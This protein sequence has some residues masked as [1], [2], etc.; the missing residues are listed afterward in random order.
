MMSKPSYEELQKEIAR[1]QQEVYA[2][3]RAE[4]NNR[5]LFDISASVNSS[6]NLNELYPAIH[7]SLSSVIDATNIFI[8]LYDRDKNVISFPYEVDTSGVDDTP[9]TGVTGKESLTARVIETRRPLLITRDEIIREREN[10]GNQIVLGR[11]PDSWLG[12]PLIAYGNLVG[13]IAV[14]S[15]EGSSFYDDNDVEILTGVADQ[16]AIAIEYKQVEQKLHES[17]ERFRIV[18]DEI[19]ELAIK[20]YNEDRQILFWN[21]GSEQLFGYSEEEAVGRQLEDLIIPVGMR[22]QVIADHE[23][24][25]ST[26]AVVPPGE[27]TLVDKFGR[28]ISVLSYHAMHPGSRGKEFFCID[29]DLRA[30]KKAEKSL[31]TSHAQFIATMDSLDVV[32]YVADMQSHEL[33]FMN[34]QAREISN[35]SIGDICWQV[36]QTGQTG[37]CPFCTNKRLIGDDGKPAPPYIWEFQN[38]KSGT[39]Y[40]CR[41]QAITWPDG[42]LVRLEIAT[43][44]DKLKSI[45][46]QLRDSEERFRVLHDASFGGICIHDQGRIVECN[47]ELSNLTGYS[48]DELCGANLL[49]LIAPSWHENVLEH[50]QNNHEKPYV[51]EGIKRDNATYDLKIHGKT[52]PYRESVV[53]VAEFRDISARLKTEK[54]LK[55]SEQRHRI[56]FEYSP[57]GMIYFSPDGTILDC[58]EKFVALMGAPREALIGFNTAEQSTPKMRTAIKKALAGESMSFED[59]YTSITG[60]KSTYLRVRFQPVTPGCSPSPVIATLEDLTERRKAEEEVRQTAERLE[61]FFSAINDAVFV[62]PEGKGQSFIVVNDIAIERYGYTREEFMTMSIDDISDNVVTG[63][64][65]DFRKTEPLSQ[66]GQT[67]FE[68]FHLKKSGERFPVEV[69]LTFSWQDRRAVKIAVVRDISERKQ[70]E[71]ERERFESQLQQAVKLESIGRLAGG[72]AHDFNNML[73]VILGRT[74]MILDEAG[75]QFEFTEDMLE[76]KKAARHSAELTG[77]LLTFA[78]KQNVMPETIDLNTRVLGMLDMLKRLL[79]ERI[80]LSWQPGD[81]LWPVRIDPSQLDQVLANL[82]VNAKDAIGDIGT[83]VISST[84]ISIK[85]KIDQKGPEVYSGDYAALSVQDDGC[86][87]APSVMENLFE[88]FFTTKGIG[89]GTGLGLSTVYGIARQNDGFVEV[90]SEEGK[91]SCFRLFLPRRDEVAQK[92]ERQNDSVKPLSE[93]RTVLLVEDEP[94]ILK[95]TKR[96]L[97]LLGYKV[98]AAAGPGHAL[99]CAL[100]YEGE[101]DLLLTDVIMPEMDGRRLAEEILEHFPNIQ[102]LFM[103]GYTDDVIAPSGVLEEGMYFLPKPFTRKMMSDKL[104]EILGNQ[105]AAD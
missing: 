86:G 27:L 43:D 75:P 101:I 59:F 21:K 47:Q 18:S 61:T 60:G 90:E 57:L 29:L 17:F 3:Q 82:C 77:Q 15:R 46:K 51:V 97:Q 42:R 39:W 33:L 91:G 49:Q 9:L 19:A 1:L 28:D 14:Q 31:Q 20:I 50:I 7:V 85:G 89:K 80:S 25:L 53:R 66:D 11:I 58:N 64:E 24:W 22:D 40:Q 98:L 10:S 54:T 69:N 83:I 44:I 41:D 105:T 37:P 93:D 103:S 16:V 34:S 32:V 63:E 2:S 87:M 99:Q 65:A 38:T 70:A 55:E 73:G 88:P 26:G 30:I 67:V 23:K 12:V 95:M 68:A 78:R 72:V 56:I 100:E 52:I 35:A 45:E 62:Y 48:R 96:M 79:G 76:I 6:A 8:A 104:K 71:K 5:A 94:A 74:E 84:N 81:E 4:K 36:M 102:C 92:T 13:V